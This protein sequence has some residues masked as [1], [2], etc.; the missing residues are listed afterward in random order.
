MMR[1]LL[2]LCL[3]F[4]IHTSQVFAAANVTIEEGNRLTLIADKTVTTSATLIAV[5]NRDRAALNCTNNDA[6]IAIRWGD[7]S[8][9]I[10]KG[11]RIPAN[12]SIEIKSSQGIYM[13]A[14]SSSVTV[15]CTE[16]SR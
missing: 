8:V 14:E 4:V 5:G 15:S 2:S 1:L 11:Q 10:S 13:A 3:L 6:A 12:A 9:T 16:E 7:S